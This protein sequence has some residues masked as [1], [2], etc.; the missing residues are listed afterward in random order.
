MIQTFG[1]IGSGSWATAL[2]K[3]L[4]GN[5]HRINWWMRNADTIQHLRQRNHNPHY[6]TSVYFNTSLLTLSNNIGEVIS[7]S[8]VLVMAVPS[9][10]VENALQTANPADFTGKKILSAIKGILPEQNVLL[11]DYLNKKYNI[12]LQNYFA[13][14]GPCH[15]EEVAAEKLSYLTFSGVDETTAM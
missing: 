5:N 12:A 13:V 10:Y 8:D 9:A 3:I 1:I 4:T 15:A 11:N 14:L 2:A 6:L 7:N